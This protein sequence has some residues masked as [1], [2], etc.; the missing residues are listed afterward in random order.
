MN[1]NFEKY[2]SFDNFVLAST[3]DNFE[4]IVKEIITGLNELALNNFLSP[5]VY[6][7][8]HT[9]NF[10]YAWN[11]LINQTIDEDNKHYIDNDIKYFVEKLVIYNARIR[12]SESVTSEILQSSFNDF[13]NFMNKGDFGT[14]CT[15]EGECFNCGARLSIKFKD[16]TPT[17]YEFKE[18]ANPDDY[19][20]KVPENSPASFLNKMDYFPAE[21]CFTEFTQV[22]NIEFKTGNLL[23]SDWFKLEE[24]TKNVE[25]NGN[26]HHFNINCAKGRSE[27]FEHYL[28]QNFISIHSYSGLDMYSLTNEDMKDA[29]VFGKVDYNKNEDGEISHHDY[30]LEKTVNS[31]LRATTIIEKETL[32]DIVNKSLNDLEKSKELVNQYIKEHKYELITRKVQPGEYTLVFDLKRKDLNDLLFPVNIPDDLNASIF[33]Y[34][35]N[36]TPSLNQ[37]PKNKIK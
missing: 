15:P 4:P 37:K 14:Y 35:K 1:I 8:D 28:K 11:H 3:K 29:F 26:I 6:S 34:P 23:I 9:T 18:I 7:D 24:F 5:I 27:A 10:S 21:K 2:I 16:W 20:K 33:L 30:K 25:V 13:I 22:K 36:L 12:K 17:F 32:V 31:G 19:L